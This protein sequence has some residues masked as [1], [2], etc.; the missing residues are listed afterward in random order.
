MI[1]RSLT[2]LFFVYLRHMA[3]SKGADAAAVYKKILEDAR[4]GIFAPVYLLMGEEPYYPD[5]ACKAIMD[6]ALQDYERDFNQTVFY[7]TDTT[8]ATVA[9]EARSFPVMAERRL[10]V[11]KEAQ[12]M[13]SHDDLALYCEEPTDS[14]VLVILL[15]GASADKR[16]S[17]YKNISKKGVVLESNA[18][19]DYEV[20]GWISSYYAGKGLSISPDA[21]ALMAEYAG[22]DLTR[23]VLE[24][25]KMLKNLPEGTTRISAADIEK[26]VGISRQFSIFELTK[27]LSYRDSAKALKIA[28][29]IGEQPKF[30]MPMASAALFNHFY[31][32]LKYEALLQQNHSPDISQ[33]QSVLQ[34]PPFFFSEYDTAVRNYPLPKCIRIIALME[35]Y[36][37]KGKGGE[38]GE[39]SPAQLLTELVSKILCT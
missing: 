17:L 22:T 8:A 5:L 24:T 29:Y 18:L 7:G 27:A 35:E 16:K 39:A 4:S 6:N 25:D 30:A 12:N 13:R 28:S 34:V 33:K 9:T 26:N 14:T 19:R 20:P 15:H 3:K 21:S 31:R 2:A 32:I 38:C 10:V 1:G 36:D 23:I 37:F 11:L